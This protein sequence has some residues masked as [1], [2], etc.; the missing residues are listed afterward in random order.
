[1]SY[2]RKGFLIY[3]ELRKYFSIYEVRRPLLV[4]Y[5]FMNLQLHHFLTYEENFMFFLFSA[6]FQIA[7][8]GQFKWLWPQQVTKTISS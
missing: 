2:M 3:E 7:H 8:G 6:A 5:E 1:M 4:I